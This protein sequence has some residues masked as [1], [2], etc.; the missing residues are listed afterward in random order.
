MLYKERQLLAKLESSG[1]APNSRDFI[2]KQKH[3]ILNI[4]QEKNSNKKSKYLSALDAHEVVVVQQIV[5][6]LTRREDGV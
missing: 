5:C 6:W 4:V 2:F 3:S 1:D